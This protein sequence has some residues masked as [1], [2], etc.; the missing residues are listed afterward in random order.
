MWKVGGSARLAFIERSLLGIRANA[1]L[2]GSIYIA[3]AIPQGEPFSSHD[4]LQVCPT[5]GVY[6]D[7]SFGN[8]GIALKGTRRNIWHNLYLS[9]VYYGLGL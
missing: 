1:H 5:G 3:D 9:I 7:T 2:E 6:L 4:R 8:F